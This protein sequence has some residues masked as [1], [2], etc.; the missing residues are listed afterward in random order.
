[1]SASTAI[2]IGSFTLP[3]IALLDKLERLA[4]AHPAEIMGEHGIGIRRQSVPEFFDSFRSLFQPDQMSIWILIPEL[5]ICDH[6]KAIPQGL[7]KDNVVLIHD[8][9]VSSG[10]EFIQGV[11]LH[12]LQIFKDLSSLQALAAEFSG[13]AGKFAAVF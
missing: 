7:R 13:Y 10:R 2:C 6:G 9:K 5:V 3:E 11:S 1:M 12:R 8:W 4:Q